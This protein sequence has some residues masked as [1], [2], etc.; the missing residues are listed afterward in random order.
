[1]FEV[2]KKDED[3]SFFRNYFTKD[4]VRD[5][6]LYMCSR[7]NVQ[8]GKFTDKSWENIRD[9]LAYAR[10]NGGVSY[11]VLKNGDYL[12]YGEL[13]LFHQFEGVELDMKYVE[14]ALP[15]VYQLWGKT[16]YL[17]CRG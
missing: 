4:L 11:L 6:D 17:D 5:L 9:Q 3:I 14:R 7:R 10:V 8:S 12:N 15:Y 2:R 1:M 16:V 13:Y